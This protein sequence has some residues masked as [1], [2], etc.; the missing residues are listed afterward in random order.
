MELLV[1]K[2]GGGVSEVLDLVLS[3]TVYC[4]TENAE[5]SSVA[6]VAARTLPSLETFPFK[7]EQGW[8]LPISNL[9][10]LAL[11]IVCS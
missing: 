8:V 5:H 1:I 4:T 11:Y 9:F 10:P 3:D 7:Q 6:E 2:E